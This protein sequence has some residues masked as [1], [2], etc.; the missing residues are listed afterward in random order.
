[1][2]KGMGEE[3]EEEEQLKLEKRQNAYRNAQPTVEDS[4]AP[5]L[6]AERTAIRAARRA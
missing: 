5:G 4:L 2:R 3:E 1:M 6:G